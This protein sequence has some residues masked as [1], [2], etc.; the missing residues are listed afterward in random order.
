M[1]YKAKLKEPP[2]TYRA[3]KLIV[4]KMVKNPESLQNEIAI[5]RRLDHPMIIRLYETF[6][7]EKNLYLVQEYSLAYSVF[8][9]AGSSSAGS[10]STATSAKVTPGN[11]SPK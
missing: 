6:E 1:V 7:D 3:I 2:H 9:R 8:A 11:S 4:K 5:L 10:S